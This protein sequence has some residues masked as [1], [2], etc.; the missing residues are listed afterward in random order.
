VIW[1]SLDNAQVPI[2]LSTYGRPVAPEAYV[3]TLR[4]RSGLNSYDEY[5]VLR[6][7]HQVSG[8]SESHASP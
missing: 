8:T 2:F 6:M 7:P 1:G 5:E 3:L 4:L